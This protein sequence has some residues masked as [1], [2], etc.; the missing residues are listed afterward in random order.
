MGCVHRAPACISSQSPG[1]TD[2]YTLSSRDKPPGLQGRPHAVPWLHERLRRQRGESADWPQLQISATRTAMH[3][4]SGQGD[5]GMHD[6]APPGRDMPKL[7][8]CLRPD[9]ETSSSS[10]SSG[11]SVSWTQDPGCPYGSL[12]TNCTLAMNPCTLL[13]PWESYRHRVTCQKSSRNCLSTYRISGGIL[14][15]HLKTQEHRWPDLQDIV[16]YVE[17]ASTVASDPVYGTRSQEVAFK[18]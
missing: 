7:A 2:R 17:E 1:D 12:L 16:E 14:V 13:A 5:P 11:D 10:P 4:R 18:Q 3:G 6:D 8:S 9:S 15:R